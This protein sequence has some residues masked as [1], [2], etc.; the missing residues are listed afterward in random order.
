MYEMN[1]NH[2]FFHSDETQPRPLYRV[3]AIGLIAAVGLVLLDIGMSFGGGDLATGSLSAAGWLAL[4]QR[5]AFLG[6]RNMGLFN[7]IS[8]LATLPL[9][10]ALYHLHRRSFPNAALLA[11]ILFVL[12]AA[13]YIANNNAMAMWSLSRLHAAAAPAGRAALE[14]AGTALLAQ[15]EDFTPGSFPGFLLNGLGSVLMMA[16]V[17]RGHI[18]PRWI[19]L[20]GLSGAAGLLALTVLVTFDPAA[21]DTA[22]LLWMVAG[23]L[24]LTWDIAMALRMFRLAGVGSNELHGLTV[25]TG[26]GAKS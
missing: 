8:P 7:M 22:M 16:V 1:A 9:Y 19:N 3:V 26:H 25:L 14:A 15:S 2:N 4:F 24:I 11:L 10:L 18:F 6:L 12:G 13:V 23:L 21:F 17:L 5:D 20:T